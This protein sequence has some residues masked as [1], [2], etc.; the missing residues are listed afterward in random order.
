[1][2]RIY[3]LLFPILLSAGC[4]QGPETL[5]EPT[6]YIQA[7]AG[8][9]N[10]PKITGRQSQP[11]PM[12]TGNAQAVNGLQASL[13]DPYGAP[14]SGTMTLAFSVQHPT[15]PSSNGVVDCQALINWTID[16][17]R[18]TR[19]ISV[20]N[21]TSITGVGQSV[22][23]Q[24]IDKTT[25]AGGAVLGAPYEVDVQVGLGVR[26]SVA[27][28]PVLNE[29]ANNLTVP[30]SSQ[31]SIIIPQDAGAVSAK[32]LVRSQAAVPGPANTTVQFVNG[33]GSSQATYDPQVQTDFVPIPPSSIIVQLINNDAANA[34]TM[35][36]IWGIDG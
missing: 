17:N 4:L 28:L 20:G 13:S 3:P 31:V 26:G 27:Q 29:A 35:T 33:F 2:P 32:V 11:N 24:L 30:P 8:A 15:V 6:E 5:V 12:V 10:M 7:D 18:V 21:G 1:M 22:M 16:G 36:L 14:E 25:T 19:R 34:V 23:V 9:D